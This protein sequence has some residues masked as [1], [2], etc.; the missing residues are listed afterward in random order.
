M[1]IIFA[2]EIGVVVNP[3]NIILFMSMYKIIFKSRGSIPRSSKE[4]KLYIYIL[5]KDE[6]TLFVRIFAWN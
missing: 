5:W 4:Y 6:E 1:L 3:V 2:R